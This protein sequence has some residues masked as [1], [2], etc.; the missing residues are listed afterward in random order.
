MAVEIELDG[1][2]SQTMFSFVAPGTRIVGHAE[3][4]T[5]LS[6]PETGDRSIVI[7]KKS[8]D[9]PGNA[10]ESSAKRQPRSL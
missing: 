10:V 1:Q 4:R 7:L 8:L 5:G 9:P 2:P 3:R 6:A